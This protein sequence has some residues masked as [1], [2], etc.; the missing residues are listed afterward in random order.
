M[1]LDMWVLSDPSRDCQD[2][3]LLL[4][5][6]SPTSWHN[7]IIVNNYIASFNKEN[8]QAKILVV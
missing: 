1:K 7:Q 3:G 5:I 4:N 2:L 8:H 6:E